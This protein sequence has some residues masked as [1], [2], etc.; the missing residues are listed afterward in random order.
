MARSGRLWDNGAQKGCGWP[1]ACRSGFITGNR[2]RGLAV[3]GPY[4]GRE[5]TQ[6]PVGNP[7]HDAIPERVAHDLRVSR[8][9]GTIVS[10]LG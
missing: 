4:R 3:S 6:S 1:L 2:R 10:T 5:S 8:A 9:G 7:A